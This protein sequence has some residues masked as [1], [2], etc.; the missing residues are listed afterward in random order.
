MRI[1][2]WSSYVCSSDL[3]SR[4]ETAGADRFALRGRRAVADIFEARH[5]STGT[6]SDDFVPDRQLA[7]TPRQALARIQPSVDHHD[8]VALVGARKT[9]RAI[10][11]ALV[12]EIDRRSVAE[13][14]RVSGSVDLGGRRIVKKKKKTQI[15]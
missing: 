7:R 4:F 15:K 5:R 10:V 13:G 2:D 9:D 11:I 3:R 12:V 1:S 8:L 6:G 14:T